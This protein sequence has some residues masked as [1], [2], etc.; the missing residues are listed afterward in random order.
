[1]LLQSL[2]MSTL[3]HLR[4]TQSRVHIP[5]AVL[6]LLVHFGANLDEADI[7]CVA[8]PARLALVNITDALPAVHVAAVGHIVLGILGVGM[9]KAAAAVDPIEGHGLCISKSYFGSR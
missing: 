1:M 2:P 9:L 5:E 4:H 3:I 7:S 6:S 8:H